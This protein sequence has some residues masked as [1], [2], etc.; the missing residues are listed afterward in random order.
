VRKVDGRRRRQRVEQPENQA[1]MTESDSLRGH[2]LISAK[3][4]RDQNFYKTVVLLVEHGSD[5]AMGL[6]INRPSCVTVAHALSE[7]F[8]LPETDDLVYVGGP[9]EPSALFILHNSAELDG[10]ESPVVPG[11]FVGS[12]AEV[13]EQIVRTSAEG[14]PD[15][16]FRI[17][18]GCAG[19]APGQLEG[20]L[21]RG[22]WHSLPAEVERIFGD[23]PY[24]VWDNLIAKVYASNRILE[25]PPCNPEWN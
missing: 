16:Q 2:C 6:V 12:S 15:I 1:A 14:D 20:E 9:V 5:G 17:F 8:K 19:W 3:R 7:H 18:S 4:L 10:N 24:A 25:Q 23:D 11:V 22:D 21:A 13:F